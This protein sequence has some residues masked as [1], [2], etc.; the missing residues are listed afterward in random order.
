MTKFVVT[1]LGDITGIRPADW[2]R[3]AG[4]DYPFL[5][6]E[7]LAALEQSGAVSPQ[8]GWQPAHLLVR[9]GTE[10]VALMPLYLKQ[11]SWGEF[12]F[13][14]QW[15]QAY[16]QQGGAYYPKLVTAIPFTPCQGTRLAIKTGYDRLELTGVLLDYIAQ[17]A[18][19]QQISSWHCLFPDP[20][21]A[22]ILQT[23]GL[24]LRHGVQFQWFNQGLNSFEDYLQ[25]LTAD[26]R[27]MLKRERRR[28]AEQ[29]ITM[30]QI[31]GADVTEQQ[32]QV[33]FRFYRLTY[34]K[35]SSQP[36]LN[37]D[38][39][40]QLASGMPEQI[41]LVFA[42]KDD[43]YVGA[44]LSM[45]GADCLYGRYWGCYEEYKSL[46]FEACYYQ[47]ID[48]CIRHH[49]KRFD[50]GAQGEHKISRGFQPVSTVS[51]HWF[52]DERFGNAVAQF[53]V[54]EQTHIETYKQQ[55]AGYLPFRQ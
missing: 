36:Y 44:A 33:F 30:L 10:L 15:A 50:S 3:L 5:K 29:G 12:V 19:E 27:K 31:S 18:G 47:G 2:N 51:A 48:Y 49:L 55:A 8:T 7:F 43:K 32:W 37:P 34:L 38:F 25:T 28:I 1:Q 17:L 13:D 54:R 39:F 11:H 41:L 24:S 4:Q 14:Q 45:I 42:I 21:Q 52:R 53:V 40:R 16:Q 6:H 20:E 22:D 9:A 26:K 23:R 46:H 35:H